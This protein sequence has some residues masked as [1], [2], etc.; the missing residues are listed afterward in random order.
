MA[1]ATV[2][3]GALLHEMQVGAG[4]AYNYATFIYS[5]L[6]PLLSSSPKS[7][8]NDSKLAL[9]NPLFML[10]FSIFSPGAQVLGFNYMTTETSLAPFD[11]WFL[12]QLHVTQ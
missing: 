3:V 7:I 5:E 4:G 1:K 6:W 11:L 9:Q 8:P 10:C 2:E 12:S